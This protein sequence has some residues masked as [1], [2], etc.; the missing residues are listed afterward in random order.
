MHDELVFECHNKDAETLK[1]LI[2]EK[3]ESALELKVPTKV[4]IGVGENWAEA[5]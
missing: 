5:K 1:K 2:R 3:M 4:D